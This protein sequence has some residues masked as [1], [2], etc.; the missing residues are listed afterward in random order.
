MPWIDCQLPPPG[1]LMLEW[2]LHQP[3]DRLR[4]LLLALLAP[5]RQGR[6]RGG[7]RCRLR[8]PAR[9][10]P[11]EAAARG[12]EGIHAIRGRPCGQPLYNALAVLTLKS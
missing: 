8:P 3:L 4:V 9:T 7:L 1:H 12:G 6:P 11:L 2:L 5:A 10:C